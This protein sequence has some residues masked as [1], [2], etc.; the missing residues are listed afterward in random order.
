MLKVVQMLFRV[1]FKEYNPR[2]VVGDIIKV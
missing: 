1:A 2:E